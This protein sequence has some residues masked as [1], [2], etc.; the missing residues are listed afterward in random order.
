MPLIVGAFGL[1]IIQLLN[2]EMLLPR[3]A[4]LLLRDHEDIGT[5]SI[6]SFEVRF[7]PDRQDALFQS[8]LFDPRT[9]RLESPTII[10]RD[11]RGRTVRRLTAT[12]ATW[13]QDH[14][15][16]GEDGRS[17]WV[18]EDGVAIDLAG[19]ATAESVGAPRRS[20]VAVDF[21]ETDLS[22]RVL[23][24]RRHG[25]YAAMLNLR[26]IDE[27]LDMPGIVKQESVARSLLRHRYSRFASV[28]VNVLVM[29][30]ALPSFLLREPSDLV[31]RSL[32][33]AAI[34]IPALIG[35]AIFMAVDLPGIAPVVGVFVPVLVLLP[36]VLGQWM[37]VKT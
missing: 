16:D 8:P 32:Q 27:V 20:R 18:L 13:T 31:L 34:T 25:E 36:I 3:V 23:T 6:R 10:E 21:Y 15:V 28:L 14:S 17:G 4:P 7:T 22:P 9:G 37:Y 26:Q 30:L 35:A 19:A 11:E 29:W 2:Q 5:E 33:C 24:V 1:S 12:R